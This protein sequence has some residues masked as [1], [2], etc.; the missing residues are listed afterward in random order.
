M[1]FKTHG[2]AR[3]ARI[4][5]ICARHARLWTIVRAIARFTKI[6]WYADLHATTCGA[7]PEVNNGR[8]LPGHDSG[9]VIGTYLA[10]STSELVRSLSVLGPVLMT[11]EVRNAIRQMHLAPLQRPV[12]DEPHLLKAWVY[13]RAGDVQVARDD[14]QRL[15]RE[16]LD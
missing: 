4:Q 13:V 3:V 5:F 9:G 1:L 12:A 11:V 7:L 16:T 10:A 2:I 14:L 8:H 15:Q 6:A